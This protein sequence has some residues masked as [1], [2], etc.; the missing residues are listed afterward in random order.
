MKKSHRKRMPKHKS[1]SQNGKVR[2]C[3][4]LAEVNKPQ[5]FQSEV[6]STSDG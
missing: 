1:Q 2:K 5:Y 6:Y 3:T 4:A